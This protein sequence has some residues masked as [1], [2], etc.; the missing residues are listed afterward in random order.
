ML[1]FFITGFNFACICAWMTIFIV[2]LAS[3]YKY[4]K[5]LKGGN[6]DE[7]HSGEDR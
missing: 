4:K 3:K 7:L 6:R 1:I 2:Y 5:S